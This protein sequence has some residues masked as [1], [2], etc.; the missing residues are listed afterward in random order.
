MV[1]VEWVHLYVNLFLAIQKPTV[2]IVMAHICCVFCTGYFAK[3]FK[4]DF[5]PWRLLL[6]LSPFS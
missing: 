3:H 2:V 6:L 1:V 5:N 4:L